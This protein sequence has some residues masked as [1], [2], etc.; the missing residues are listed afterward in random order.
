MDPMGATVFTAP[1][2]GLMMVA[3]NWHRLKSAVHRHRKPHLS[4]ITNEEPVVK[5]LTEIEWD[6]N[7]TKQQI[8]NINR[9]GEIK[10]Q[11]VRK[12]LGLTLSLEPR[13]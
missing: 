8:K 1:G 9:K 13:A 7:V 5:P 12:E 2:A 10:A 3:S 6:D 11:E 4:V